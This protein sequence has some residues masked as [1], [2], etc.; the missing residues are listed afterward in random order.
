MPNQITNIP[1]LNKETLIKLRA[2]GMAIERHIS[3]Q[4]GVSELMSRASVSGDAAKSAMMKYI[5]SEPGLS[6]V[7]AISVI[8]KT[9]CAAGF[10]AANSAPYVSKHACG[11]RPC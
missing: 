7:N 8:A 6:R 2:A 11:H 4:S 10:D 9:C 5:S 1:M 3:G